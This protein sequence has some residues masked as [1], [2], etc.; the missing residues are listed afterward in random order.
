MKIVAQGTKRYLIELEDGTFWRYESHENI[1][2][3]NVFFQGQ[4]SR[5][6][7][8]E[9]TEN[10]SIEKQILRDAVNAREIII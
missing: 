5:G 7:W 1:T 3:K 9:F 6:T 10:E 2:F 4:L 8:Y